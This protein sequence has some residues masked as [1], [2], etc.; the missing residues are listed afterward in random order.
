MT[1]YFVMSFHNPNMKTMGIL[2][3]AIENCDRRS[4]GI[5]V[6]VLLCSMIYHILNHIILI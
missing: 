3:C 2:S 4:K 6:D 1:Y 5:K